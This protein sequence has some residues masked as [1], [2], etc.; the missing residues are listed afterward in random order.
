MDG[1]LGILGILAKLKLT[2]KEWLT[3]IVFAAMIIGQYYTAKSNLDVRLTKIEMSLDALR[4][5]DAG[6]ASDVTEFKTSF[7]S[8]Q[9]LVDLTL[10]AWGK[11]TYHQPE[12]AY[13][14]QNWSKHGKH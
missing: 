9:Q 2:L 14:Y 10:G 3:V 6:I 1:I 12:G 4:T 5:A 8:W 13:A 11:E 7:R